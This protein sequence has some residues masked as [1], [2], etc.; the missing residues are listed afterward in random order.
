MVTN[1]M[2]KEQNILSG[3]RDLAIIADLIPNGASVL[4]L[5]CGNGDLLQMLKQERN[6]YACG[7]EVSQDNLLKCVRKCVPVIHADLDDGLGDFSDDSFDYVILSRTIQAVHRPDLL[8]EEMTRVGRQ[9]IVSFL[10]I[11]YAPSRL[12]L[13]FRGRMPVTKA[14]PYSWYDT[15]NIH[16]GTIKDFRTLCSQ[17]GMKITKEIPFGQKLCIMARLWPNLCAPT[18]VFVIEKQ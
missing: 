3:R 18:C 13:T 6:I 10:N 7:V 8:L 9:S 17:N 11:G 1:E 12:Q 14:L 2:K 5:G 15:P 4:D 16:L